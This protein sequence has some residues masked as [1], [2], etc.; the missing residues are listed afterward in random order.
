MNTDIRRL[1]IALPITLIIC[2]VVGWGAAFA[3]TLEKLQ[4]LVHPGEAL[5]CDVSPFIQCT[6]NLESAQGAVLG[7]PNPIIGLGA[8]IAPLVVAVGLLAG[9]RFARWFW[10]VFNLGMLGGWLFVCWLQLQS[11][12]VLGTLCSW[13]MLTW[14]MMIPAFWITTFYCISSGKWSSA[15]QIRRVGQ[16]LLHWAPIVILINYVVIAVAAQL[17]FDLIGYFFR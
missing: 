1:P 4:S 17:R 14:A 15:P 9:A 7:F 12:V 2:S 16:G 10:V 6:K 3:L 11:I 8:W 5:I 13:C